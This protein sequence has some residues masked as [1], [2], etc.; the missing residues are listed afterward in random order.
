MSSEQEL[1]TDVPTVGARLRRVK[2]SL[3]IV[4]GLLDAARRAAAADGYLPRTSIAVS[5]L[6]SQAYESATAAQSQAYWLQ[7]QP[8]AVLAAP[9]PDADEARGVA[10]NRKRGAR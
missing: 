10:R 1:S 6:I 4:L 9:A 7:R 5:D 3:D 8:A 2:A